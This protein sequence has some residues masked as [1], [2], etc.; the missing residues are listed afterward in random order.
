MQSISM[1]ELFTSFACPSQ[2]QHVL[3]HQ[4]F[5]KNSRPVDYIDGVVQAV[6][7]EHTEDG[8]EDFLLVGG[9]VCRHVG[10]NCRADEVAVGIL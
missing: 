7:V 3:T 10:D 5:V 1:T 2:L 8:P 4:V 6:N 9:H